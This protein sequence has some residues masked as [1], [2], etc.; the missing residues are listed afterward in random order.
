MQV[1]LDRRHVL[2]HDQAVREAA[3]R[4]GL[5]AELCAQLLRRRYRGR[6]VARH[7]RRRHDEVDVVGEVA[8]GV[9]RAGAPAGDLRLVRS[10]EEGTEFEVTFRLAAA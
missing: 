5:R 4:R 2:A 8:A 6:P 9:E 3:L 1:V 10:D 7:L